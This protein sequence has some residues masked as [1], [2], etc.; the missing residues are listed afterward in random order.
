V[1]QVVVQPGTVEA[2]EAAD[3]YAKVSG[4][5]VEQTVDIGS[6]VKAGDVLARIAVPEYEK[7][8]QRDEARVKAANARVAQMVAHKVAAEARKRAAEASIELARVAVR[9]KAAFRQFREKRLKRIKELVQKGA[10][11]A[12]VEDEQEDYYQSAFEAENAA[13]AHVNEAREQAAAAT[14]EVAKAQADVEAAQA[15]VAVAEADLARAKVLVDYAVI[16]SPYTGVVTRRS[17]SPGAAGQFGAFI[18]AADQGGVVPLLTVE[19]TDVMRVVVQVP[20]QYVRYLSTGATAVVE[21]DALRGVKFGADGRPLHVSRWAKGEDPVT[22]TMRAEID[23]QNPQGLL[24]SAMYGHVTIALA[25]G[26]PT[27]AMRIPSSAL[28]GKAEDGNGKV[29][30]VRAGRVHLAPV[31]YASDNG[32]EAEVTAGLTAADEVILRADG[33]VEEG[34]P[35]TVNSGPAR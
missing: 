22:R 24:Q 23:V 7:Q 21:I 33:P 13:L 25:E 31:R 14:A 28:V 30:V 1:Q 10:L 11:D 3:L 12:N 35:V 9:A 27:A 2:F 8:V 26:V 17:F 18:K 34:T 5:L 32:V 15:E 16:R 19:R 6:R 20:D 4:Y 29:R